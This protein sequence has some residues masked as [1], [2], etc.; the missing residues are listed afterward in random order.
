[1][2]Y[3]EEK[4]LKDHSK[5]IPINILEKLINLTKKC[6]CKINCNDGSHGSGFFCLINLDEFNNLIPTLITNYHVLKKNDV[7]LSKKINFSLDNGKENYV[8]EIDNG[9]KVYTSEIYDVTIIEIKKKD[10]LRKENFL[11]IDN[12]IFKDINE[13]KQKPIY[14]LHYP[15]GK[16]M[17]FSPGVIQSI[18]EDNYNIRHVCDSDPGSS[19]GVLINTIDFGVLGI[20][21]GG[22]PGNQNYNV[23]T[24]FKLPIEEF[25]NI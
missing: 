10:N 12:N 20:H 18:Y 5:S 21:K 25:K 22:A 7:T 6:V 16:E 17:N 24:F 1:M 9:R 3:I 15:K 2:N 23:G 8:I 19:G 14:L 11:N 13:Y 4:D